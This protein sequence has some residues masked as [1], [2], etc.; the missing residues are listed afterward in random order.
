M[1]YRLQATAFLL[2]GLL[3]ATPA[4]ASGGQIVV[5]Q[6]SK[7][8]PSDEGPSVRSGQVLTVRGCNRS[9]VKIFVAVLY[10]PVG[11]EQY[12]FRDQGWFTL[13]DGECTMLFTTDNL[14]FSLRA[15]VAGNP[16]RYWGQGKFSCVV[17][18]G[19]YEFNNPGNNQPCPSGTESVSFTEVHAQSFG[20]FTYTFYP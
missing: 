3:A 9:G 4:T 12:T 11:F 5:A 7:N 1:A 2:T 6:L 13:E 15:E 8:V 19:P 20:T 10:R 17:Y 18:P 14:Y 16:G